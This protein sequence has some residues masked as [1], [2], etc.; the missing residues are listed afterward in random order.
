MENGELRL[1]SGSALVATTRRDGQVQN[2]AWH[3]F[4]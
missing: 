1:S 4:F 3:L 2:G